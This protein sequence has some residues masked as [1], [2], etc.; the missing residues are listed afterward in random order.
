MQ[1]I[2]LISN[3]LATKHKI[4]NNYTW[5][6]LISK[7]K[8]VNEKKNLRGENQFANPTNIWRNTKSIA[9]TISFSNSKT[10]FFHPFDYLVLLLKISIN[11]QVSIFLPNFAHS[12]CQNETKSSKIERQVEKPNKCL[13]LLE[14]SCN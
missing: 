2:C 4:Q 9:I 8:F 13:L 7:H 3:Y 10:F 6:G 5:Y 12:R 1:I 14:I 11:L